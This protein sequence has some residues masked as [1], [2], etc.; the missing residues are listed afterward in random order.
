M[1]VCFGTLPLIKWR[2]QGWR[3]AECCHATA[4]DRGWLRTEAP[5]KRDLLPR[6]PSSLSSTCTVQVCTCWVP[7]ITS[8]SY[9]DACRRLVTSM[10]NINYRSRNPQSEPSPQLF[11][12]GKP[13]QPGAAVLS[14]DFGTKGL[15]K[16]WIFVRVLK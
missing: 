11:E 4:V 15:A 14:L 2:P 9:D 3:G 10:A 16:L 8:R 5:A 13:R 1:W 7:Q 12:E 6:S